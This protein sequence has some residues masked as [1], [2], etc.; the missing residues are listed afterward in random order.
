[1]L[2]G[3]VVGL[4]GGFSDHF[5]QD[6][7][8]IQSLINAIR[9][10]ESAFP[11]DLSENA[12]ELRACAA[13]VVGEILGHESDSTPDAGRNARCERLALRHRHRAIP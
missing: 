4:V 2:L 10:H 11:E 13:I 7:A 9:T 5:R 6:S 8:V 12:L 3:Y 1:M